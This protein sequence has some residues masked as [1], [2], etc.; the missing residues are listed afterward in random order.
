LALCL[1][2]LLAGQS[3]PTSAAPDIIVFLA[4]DLGAGDI[5]PQ[6]R[7]AGLLTPNIDALGRAGIVYTAGYGQPA[8][9][10]A[11]TAL[12]SG[13]WP[14]RRSIGAVVNNGP[15]PLPAMVTIAERLRALGY[16]THL[17]GKWHLGFGP[18]RHP[19]DQGFDTF[20]GFEGTTPNYVGDDPRAPLFWQRTRIQNFGNVT[21]TLGNEAVRVLRS[22]LTKPQFLFVSWTAPHD[23]LQGTLAQRIAE[24]DA[25]IGRIVAAARPD[26][27]I[28]FAGDNGRGSNL[29]FRGQKYD[30]LEGGVRVPFLL[31]WTGRVPPGLRID[32]PASLVDIAPTVVKAAGGTFNDSDGFDLLNLPPNRGVFFKAYRGDPGLGMR[33]AQW[34]FYRNYLG[35]NARLYNVVSDPGEKHNI[36]SSNKAVIDQM[37]RMLDNF[38]VALKK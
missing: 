11:R 26:S 36:A 34:K 1:T 3:R 19:L 4:D 25:N 15:P 37:S 9:V 18:G 22:A 32:T 31:T 7:R 5:G 29:P 8:C 24:M 12:M 33:R 27:L 14:Q 10:Q 20:L 35:R 21:D 17:V 30:I 23:P 16:R 28:I 2:F 38:A 13:K 6:R